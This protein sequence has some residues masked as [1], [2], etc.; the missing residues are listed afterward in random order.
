MNLL[1]PSLQDSCKCPA[2]T[3]KQALEFIGGKIKMTAK[4]FK[5]CEPCL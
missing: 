1:S 2:K 5:Y 4:S 3:Q